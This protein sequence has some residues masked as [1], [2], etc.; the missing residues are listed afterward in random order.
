MTITALD[1]RGM[2][3]TI[4]QTLDAHQ[5]ELNTL[6]SELG[7][8]DHGTAISTGF[9][10]SVEQL[11][12]ATSPFQVLYVT[13]TNL[14]NRM[15]GSSGA[16]FGTLF[17]GAA[18]QVKEAQALSM[19]QFI[20]MWESGSA[21]VMKRGKAQPGDKTMI[22][23]LVPAVNSMRQNLDKKEPLAAILQQA[24]ASAE[25]GAR[26]TKDMQAQYGRARYLGERSIGQIDPGA[27][28]VALMFRA[29]NDY[30]KGK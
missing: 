22:D 4:S 7:D 15:G 14:M 2:I 28:S 12:E 20:M 30:W 13:G 18:M 27:Q 23:A 17:V 26:S 10:C 11:L 25:Q 5:S 6:D 19:E 8:G 29:I 24:A 3:T 16:L 21:G 1:L 9:A